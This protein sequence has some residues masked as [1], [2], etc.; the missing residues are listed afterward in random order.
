MSKGKGTF[1]AML[2]LWRPPQDAGDPIGCLATTYTFAPGLFDEQCLARFLEIESEPNRE[3]LAFL[4]E[5]ESRLGGA[6]AGVLVDYTQAG[7]EHSL[8]W[9]VLPVRIRAGKQHAKLSLLAW[10]RHIRIIVASA[11]LTE[12]GY[13][14]NHEVAAA[15]D[16][17]PEDANIEMLTAS[18][19][20]FRGLI[21]FV[22]G[23]STR[24]PEVVRAE[25][26]LAKVER[27]VRGWQPARRGKAVRQQLVFT[28]PATGTNQ[29][30]RRGMEEAVEACRRR[31]GSPTEAWVASPFFDSDDAA[32]R[33]TASLCKLMARG[34][35]RILGFCVPTI[36]DDQT[37]AMPRLAAPKTLLTAPENYAGEVVIETLPER[38]E[39]K[40]HRP[41]HAKMLALYAEKYAALMIGSANFTCAGMGIGDRLNA[42]A[43]LLTIV[44]EEVGDTARHIRQLDGLWSGMQRIS[45]PE[46]A[47]WL[48]ARPDNEE[49][50]QST[51]APP[52]SG[53]L[54]ASYRA[55][56]TRRI[57]MRLDAAGLPDEWLV[58]AFGREERELLSARAWGEMGRPVNA[59]IDWEPLQPPEKL[60]VRWDDREAF[61]PINVE[62]S[63]ELPAPVQLQNMSADDL[64]GIL[65]A[66]DPSAAFRA[67]AIR[68][69]PSDLFDAD[70]DSATPIDLDPLRRYDLHATFLHR[71][72]RKA[73]I[74]AQL[75]SN[76]QRPVWGRQALEW[77]L[78]G[79]IGIEPLADRL[80]REF[81]S[82]GSDADE[83][84]LTLADFLIVLREVDYQPND[85]S[86]SKAEFARVFR[87]FLHQLAERLGGEVEAQRD[88]VSQDLMQFWERVLERCR[89]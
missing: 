73:R 36:R 19:A 46:A 72:R 66:A 35:R 44:D 84:L 81:A 30:P 42:E 15:A 62:D 88:R 14:S 76:L 57:V 22:P 41:W 69:E 56:E 53:F 64:L 5:R 38:D 39:D 16:L 29:A 9:D 51:T 4:L 43:N 89:E 12:Q 48:G 86:L 74:L 28:L 8:R 37:A 78:W 70:L 26:F 83:A 1:G 18:V 63:R 58:L 34:G 11:N 20:F 75:R 13:R 40:N 55:G 24:P 52:P 27:Q 87:P 32:G 71:V 31:G 65:A 54:S 60:L 23:A 10:S 85:G 59:E 77:R 61:L 2:E 80:T 47:E 49:E 7:V 33:V 50:E 21:T 79:L 6:Y 17:K 45:D 68:Q 67:W 82:A 3:D 25:D